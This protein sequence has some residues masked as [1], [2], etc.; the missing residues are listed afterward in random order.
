[1]QHSEQTRVNCFHHKQVDPLMWPVTEID[2]GALR[3]ELKKPHW[4]Y[5]KKSEKKAHFIKRSH[6]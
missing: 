5:G 3:N 1:M 2:P 6:M 4:P